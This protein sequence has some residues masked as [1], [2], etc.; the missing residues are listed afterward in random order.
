V[1]LGLEQHGS[2]PEGDTIYRTATTLR[3]W[4]V[5]RQ[6]TAVRAGVV[7]L[8]ADRLM[9]TTVDAVESQG[10]HLLIRFSSGHT[11][12]SHMRMTGSWHV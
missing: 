6:V 8:P 2:V 9:G 1:P 3:R 12:H 5:G 10:K 7:R 4:L 11:L